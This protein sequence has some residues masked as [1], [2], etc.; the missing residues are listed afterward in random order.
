MRRSR[1]HQW[2]QTS[3]HEAKYQSHNMAEV[4]AMTLRFCRDI[5][6]AAWITET[7][8]TPMQLI[9]FGPNIYASY[10]RLRFIPDPIHACQR[11]STVRVSED[12]PSDLSQARRALRVLGAFT[13]TPEDCYF[14]IW[15]G[16]SDLELP[17]DARGGPLLGLSDRSYAILQGPL[18][19]I[20]A[21]EHQFG[22]GGPT[23][24]P[25][26]VWPADRSWFFASD[27]DPH[28]AG[29]GGAQ[30][31]ISAL[32]DDPELDIVTAQP[33][34]RQPMYR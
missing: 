30:S 19:E 14:C 31:A 24:P 27:V 15:D 6:V 28:W 13:S 18:D 16:Y 5:A 29:I 21:W 12:H 25:A 2:K 26:L 23:H 33:S 32:I 7:G 17:P 11:E 9:D 10:G 20:D 34:E 3:V 22:R 8:T 1:L 4:P